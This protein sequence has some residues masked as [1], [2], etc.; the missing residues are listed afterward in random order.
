MDDLVGGVELRTI[1]HQDCAQ[2]FLRFGKLHVL[3]VTLSGAADIFF[4]S[5]LV[6]E[7]ATAHERR[8][9]GLVVR[10]RAYHIRDNLSTIYLWPWVASVCTPEING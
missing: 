2:H 8:R 6:L 4:Y 7:S 9:L 10:P 5:A 1:I 3:R